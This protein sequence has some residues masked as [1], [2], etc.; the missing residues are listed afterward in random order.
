MTINR[1]F[2]NLLNNDYYLDL[3]AEAINKYIEEN[4]D[5]HV[6]DTEIHFPWSDVTALVGKQLLNS[7]SHNIVVRIPV[8]NPALENKREDLENKY[9]IT[10]Y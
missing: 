1:G 8:Y 6:N 3:K 4:L 2:L 10:R 7:L 9:N 5:A